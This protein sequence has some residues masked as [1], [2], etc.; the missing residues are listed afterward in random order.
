MREE[1]THG[2][3][4]LAVFLE[5]PGTT[6]IGADPVSGELAVQFVELGLGI[7]G[8]HVGDAARHEAEDDVL[9]LGSKMRGWRRNQ[10]RVG[11][12][13]HEG[14]QGGQSKPV[15]A[16]R[17]HLASTERTADAT[18]TPVLFLD[19]LGHDITSDR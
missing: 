2:H 10:A 18:R 16:Q 14:G 6:L 3:A 19:S 8:V 1:L 9:D 7:E 5:G 12:F 17:K 4:R 13:S 15:G 11:V